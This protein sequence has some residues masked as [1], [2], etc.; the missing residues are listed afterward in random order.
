[1][2]SV[3]LAAL[4][5]AQAPIRDASNTAPNL[6][7]QEQTVETFQ[8]D[9]VFRAGL[10]LLLVGHGADLWSTGKCIGAQ[11]CREANPALS[12]A[13]DTEVVFGAVKMAGAA[14]EIW[15]LDK[16]H[17]KNKKAGRIATYVL[18]GATIGIGIRNAREASK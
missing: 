10:A 13:Q 4:L 5:V 6:R 11:T 3:L 9:N 2:I 8:K 1:M 12:W 18:A 17:K 7:T 14:A 15:A 16:L